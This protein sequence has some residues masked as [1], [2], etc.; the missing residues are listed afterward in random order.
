VAKPALK[1]IDGASGEVVEG[2]DSNLYARIEELELDLANAERDLRK[3]R[4]ANKLL[5]ADQQKA[6]DDY[7]QRE[8]VARLFDFW[9]VRTGHRKSL[10]TPDR[11]DAIKKALDWG[12]NAR[13]VAL[14]IA[15]CAAH[16]YVTKD[17]VVHDDLSVILRSGKMLEEYAR[18]APRKS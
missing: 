8:L 11:F 3:A 14:A 17:R 15:G 10:L 6:R 16:P 7:P 2:S 13:Q 1:L 12:Y 5:K 9:Q 18:K 4:R